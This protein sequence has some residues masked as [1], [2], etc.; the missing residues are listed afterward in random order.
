MNAIANVHCCTCNKSLHITGDMSY[1]V[2]L[3]SCI[4]DISKFYSA[5]TQDGKVL[6]TEPIGLLIQSGGKQS[7][8]HLNINLF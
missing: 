6:T 1:A 8:I 4:M 2:S 3:P 7:L 5:K